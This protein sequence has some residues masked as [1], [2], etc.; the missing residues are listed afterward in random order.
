MSQ[1]TR[2]EQER[3]L[4]DVVSVREWKSAFNIPN[5]TCVKALLSYRWS[6]LSMEK[7]EELKTKLYNFFTFAPVRKTYTLQLLTI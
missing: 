1:I 4:V 6:A 3:F 2:P 7:E 5:K